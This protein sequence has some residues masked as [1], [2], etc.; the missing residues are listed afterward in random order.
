MRLIGRDPR[1]SSELIT[2]GGVTCHAA[3]SRVQLSIAWRFI[4]SP[5]SVPALAS[6][7]L[8]HPARQRRILNSDKTDLQM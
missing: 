1:F 7:T 5:P 8:A 4:W 2:N 6:F 3:A